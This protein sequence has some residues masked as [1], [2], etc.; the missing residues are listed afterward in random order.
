MDTVALLR[1]LPLFEE[2]ND[3]MLARLAERC[4]PRALAAGELLFRAGDSCRGL[5]VLVSG[6]IRV[7]RVHVDGREQ[8]LHVE[9]AGR[10]VGELPL[11]DGG[12]YPASAEAIE[13]SRLVFLSRADFEHLYRTHPEIA[14]AVI[15]ALGRRLRH[16]V[17][18]AE[19]LAFR[20]VAARL[21][22]LL[23]RD[24]ERGGR[25]TSAGVVVTLGRTHEEIARE[26]GTAR[27]SVSRAVKQLRS[28]GLIRSA[29]RGRLLIPD[30]D[31]LRAMAHGGR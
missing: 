10:P 29:G 22:L 11:F 6:R 26:I 14:H 3:P 17:E 23:A 7:F 24:A 18:L 20:D 15:R 27:E 16:L 31:R 25:R 12:T 13:P 30:P 4:V 21:A 2:L 19:T 9:T 28:R 1:A 5:Y 8:V